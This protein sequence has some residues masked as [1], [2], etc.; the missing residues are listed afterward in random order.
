MTEINHPEK[1]KYVVVQIIKDGP[2]EFQG[3]VVEPQHLFSTG[4]QIFAIYDSKEEAEKIFPNLFKENNIFDNIDLYP[5]GY[6]IIL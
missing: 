5:H 1:T 3:F 4:N 6:K 2:D